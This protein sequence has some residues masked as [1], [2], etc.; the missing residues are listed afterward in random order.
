MIKVP[1]NQ[2]IDQYNWTLHITEE[3]LKCELKDL[4]DDWVNNPLASYKRGEAVVLRETLFHLTSDEKWLKSLEELK[5]M[6]I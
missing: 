1:D 5:E 4:S 3:L 6:L 2:I